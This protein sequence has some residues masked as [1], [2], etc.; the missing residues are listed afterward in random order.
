MRPQVPPIYFAYAL[1]G[2]Y[3][4]DEYC[5][6]FAP[7]RKRKATTEPF[8]K[9]NIYIKKLPLEGLCAL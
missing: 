4:N 1:D 5:D 9:K 6:M 3:L 2:N 7:G 8:Q